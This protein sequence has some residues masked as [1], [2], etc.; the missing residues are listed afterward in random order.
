MQHARPS[1]DSSSEQATKIEEWAKKR[2]KRVAKGCGYGAG[3]LRT[4]NVISSVSGWCVKG[5][6]HSGGSSVV[7]RRGGGRGEEIL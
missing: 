1:H 7:P 4:T 3:R 6:A 5:G 2:G